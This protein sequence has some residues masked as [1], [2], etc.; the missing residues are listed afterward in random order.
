MGKSCLHLLGLA[1][2]LGAC[3]RDQNLLLREETNTNTEKLLNMERYLALAPG[4]ENYAI[5]LPKYL[6]V[7]GMEAQPVDAYKATIGRVLFYDKNLSRDRTIACASC[8]KQ[9]LAFSDDQAFSRGI[10]GRH[11]LRNS[12]PLAN[13]AGM[14][15][16]YR[17]IAGKPAPVFLWDNRAGSISELSK[18]A[19]GNENE[20]GLNMEQVVARVA[21]QP[22]YPYLWERAY[23]AAPVSEAGILECLTAFV[24]AMG[25]YNTP[26]DRSLEIASGN[27]S[28]SGLDTVVTNLYYGTGTSIVKRRLPGLTELEDDGRTLFVAKCTKCHS[29]VRP[30]QEVFEACNGLEMEYKD[31]GKGQLTGQHA[32]AGV[33]KSP[34]LRNIALTAPYMHDGRFKTLEEVVEFYSTGVKNHP[35][36]HELMRDAQGRPG[37]HFTPD[38][39]KALIAFLHTLSDRTITTDLRFSNPILQ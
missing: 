23:G 27:L 20:M 11:S 26:L 2:L 34:S 13:V 22:Y 5:K 3:T 38:E 24:N 8:H 10:E 29:P 33:F 14:S 32:D 31:A 6:R 1:L 30:F 21:E 12:M 37:F 7:L 15:A 9:S 25:S 18:M 4:T 16:H 39:K 28:I 19:F 35:N 17:S 36:L